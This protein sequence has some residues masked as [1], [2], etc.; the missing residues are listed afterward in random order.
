MGRYATAVRSDDTP[1]LDKLARKIRILEIVEINFRDL[2]IEVVLV[3]ADGRQ[4]AR[5][6]NG[7]HFQT[8]VISKQSLDGTAAAH[9]R[10][11]SS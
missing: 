10:V 3:P 9:M 11:C 4:E 8:H 2:A 6:V 7:D 5:R 1:E